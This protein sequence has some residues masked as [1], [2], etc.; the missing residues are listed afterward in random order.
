MEVPSG[1]YGFG[2]PFLAILTVL[3]FVHELGHYLVA[4][5]NGVRVE[6]FSIGFGP[7]LFGWTD[8]AKTR[9][10]FSLI[11]LGGYVKMFGDADAASRPDREVSDL[12]D[13]ERQEAFPHKRLGQR[14]WIVAAGPIANFL[15]AILLLAGVFVAFGQPFTPPV[16]GTVIPDSAAERAGLK[17]EDRIL[18]IDGADIH[19][20]QDIQLIVSFGLDEAIEI[21]VLRD[22]AEIELTAKP[23]LTEIT[24]DFGNQQ[25]VGR[26]G[27]SHSGVELV[28]HG[29]LTALW[30]ATERTGAYTVGILKA[31]GQM[32]SGDRSAT[33][34][35]GP[36]QIA[37][38]SGQVAEYGWGSVVQLMW[39]L[40]ISLGLINLFPIPILDGGHLLFYAIE[41]VRG[42]PLG[43]RAQEY[44]FRIGI[45]L[46]V[47]LM[48]FVTWND[49]VHRI[50]VFDFIKDLVT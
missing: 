34:L 20:F 18:R 4:R 21:V 26:L 37:K 6:V 24:D 49:I 30:R 31:V 13:E 9:W 12:S 19:S 28:R 50:K 2:L 48:V 46:V 3:V 5:L 16:V 45:A 40:S 43:E 35:G 33:E 32:I 47:S 25:K 11:P 1:L 41:A 10:K 7:E 29:P 36:L 44:G 22:G 8:K 38:M 17:P 23:V 42:R 14:S 27:I 39:A 15:F